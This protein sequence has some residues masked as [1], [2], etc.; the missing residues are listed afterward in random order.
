MV[1]NR[2]IAVQDYRCNVASPYSTSAHYAREKTQ[3]KRNLSLRRSSSVYSTAVDH[4]LPRFCVFWGRK[5][6]ATHSQDQMVR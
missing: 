2:R 4:F 6:P 3:S 1:E 5:K